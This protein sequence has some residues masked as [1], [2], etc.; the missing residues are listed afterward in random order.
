LSKRSIEYDT[1]MTLLPGKYTIKLLAR[2]D[3]TGRIGTFQ[4]SF[5]I[6][7]LNEESNRVAISSVVLRAVSASC[8]AGALRIEKIAASRSATAAR[9]CTMSVGS[10]FGAV[11]FVY[12]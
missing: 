12:Q 11:T 10:S 5:T 7:N 8:K 1:G 6:P 2:D 3:E 9:M 4:T